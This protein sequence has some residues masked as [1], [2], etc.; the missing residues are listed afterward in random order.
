MD[1]SQDFNYFLNAALN[2]PQRQAVAQKLGALFVTAGAGS[3]KTRVIT[4]RVANLI[5]NEN[6]EPSSIVGLTFTNKAAGEMKERLRKFLNVH[7]RLPFIGTFH[8]YCLLLLRTNKHLLPFPNFSIMDSDDQ[9]SLIKK[10]IKKNAL[11]KQVSAH[12]VGYQLS[13]YKNKSMLSVQDN[14]FT[15]PYLRDIYFEYE[16]EKSV[17]HSFDFDDLMIYAVK[18]FQGNETFK[19]TFQ[20]NIRHILVDEYQ[21]TNHI[22]HLLLKNMALDQQEKFA[23]DSVCAV[24]DEDQSIYSWRG[25]TI[26]N[27]LKFSSDFAPVTHVKIEQN[28]RSVQQILEIANK[29]IMN[30]KLRNPKNLWS[31]RQ[32]KNRVVHGRCRSGE[33]EATTAALFI[34]AFNEE[35][36][37]N[38]IAILYRTHYQSRVIEEA[39]IYN[40]IPYKIV[41]GIRFYERKEIKD[42]LAYLRLCINPYDKLS[43]MR[44]INCPSRGLG[45]KFEDELMASWDNQPFLDFKQLL[46]VM[47][48]AQQE[49]LTTTKHKAVTDFLTIFDGIDA[50]NSPLLVIDQILERAEYLNYLRNS[51]DAKEAEEKV[52]NIR[53]LRESATLFEYDA[54]LKQTSEQNTA[55]SAATLEA[56]LYDISLMQEKIENNDDNNQVPLMTLHAAKG[57]EFDAVIIAG[58]EENLLPSAKSLVGNEELEEERRLFYVGITRAKDYLLLL[59]AGYRNMLGQIVD[60]LPSRF[61]SEIPNNLLNTKDFENLNNSQSQ[62]FFDQ[63]L[64]GRTIAPS[65]VTFGPACHFTPV[66]PFLIKSQS[67]GTVDRQMSWQKNQPVL[68]AKFGRGIVTNVEKADGEEYYITAIFKNGKKKLLSSYLEKI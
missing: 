9:Q 42:I 40:G 35:K 20:Q 45:Q 58:L 63:W 65:I 21:D 57:L 16:S 29:V 2:E 7:Y 31:D 38:S 1:K 11:T 18:I 60:Q 47:L 12:Q 52:E 4:A 46:A 36:K 37:N 26:T 32:A 67:S 13:Q 22:Q 23:I 24:G 3:G 25:A 30:N 59:S 39:L 55:G 54:L 62:S 28:Y 14:A 61:L 51:Y 6:V 48:N 43:L 15:Y 49:P 34:K 64:S 50:T 41:G 10:I 19:T 5:I 66:Q 8:S 56:F 68:H 17:S 44:V 27:M 33:Q 53:E